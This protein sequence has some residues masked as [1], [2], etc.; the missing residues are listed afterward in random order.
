MYKVILGLVLVFHARGKGGSVVRYGK[1]MPTQISRWTFHILLHLLYSAC[2]ILNISSLG[3]LL[4]INH[5]LIIRF[6]FPP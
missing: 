3:M 4:V 1:Q 5:C 6:I 2:P